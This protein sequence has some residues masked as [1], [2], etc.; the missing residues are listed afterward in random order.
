MKLLQPQVQPTAAQFNAAL[1]DAGFGVER[2]R[3]ID[4]SG[5]C[6]GFVT[7]P[8]F[9]RRGVIDR[10]RTLAKGIR[11]RDAEITRRALRTEPG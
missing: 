1:K 9:R 4:V 6:P 7:T 11:E 8:A 10:N 5:R 2:A 3:I